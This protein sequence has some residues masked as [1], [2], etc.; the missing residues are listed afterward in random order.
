[1]PLAITKSKTAIFSKKF[2][3]KDHMVVNYGV[4]WKGFFG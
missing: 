3:V 1:M 2:M 4:I